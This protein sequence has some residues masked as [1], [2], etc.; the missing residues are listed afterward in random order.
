ME[1]QPTFKGRRSLP[2]SFTKTLWGAHQIQIAAV[3]I[4][5]PLGGYLC[6]R[7]ASGVGAYLILENTANYE[8]GILFKLRNRLWTTYGCDILGDDR[9][10]RK[11]RNR[12]AELGLA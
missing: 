12:F 9:P 1:F 2:S 8:N 7:K 11:Y 5:M 6:G 10:S 4:Q 3:D